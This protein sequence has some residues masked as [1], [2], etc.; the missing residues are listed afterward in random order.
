MAHVK[1][2]LIRTAGTNCDA[3]AEFAWQ[4]AGASVERVHVQKLA[5]NPGLLRNFQIITLPGGFSYGD[6]ISAGRIFAAQLERCARDEFR[7]FI[8]DGK[9]ILAICNGFQV[10][11][12]LGLLPFSADIGKAPSAT[13]THNAPAGFQD[14]WVTLRAENS[15]CVFL[16]P[17]RCYD[18]PI[19][20]GE[21]R[22]V[23]ASPDVRRRV[24]EM[25][26]IATTY[27]ESDENS[28]GAAPLPTFHHGP[29]NPNGSIDDIAGLCDE[30]G[31]VFGLMPHPERHIEFT[32]HPCW[33][34]RPRGGAGDG[35]AIFQRAVAARR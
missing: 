28:R 13:L 26:L 14:R 31:R 4:K 33:T 17:G 1:V 22:V 24:R 29:A 35:L 20:H 25:R 21:G 19:G 23:F 7:R 16:E 3:E 11:V 18:M 8:D 32:Q 27:V 10:A 12:K 5:Q 15:P 34:S 9:L 6:D 2:I 30:T